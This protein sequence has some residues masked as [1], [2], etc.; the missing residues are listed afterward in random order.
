MKV[1]IIIP[2][3]NESETLLDIIGRVFAQP[4]N[5]EK[6]IVI[7]D[8]KSTDSSL[9]ILHR[10]KQEYNFALCEHPKNLGK[11]AALNTGLTQATGDIILFQDADLEY[12]PADWPKLIALFDDQR[13]QVVYGCRTSAGY[14]KY[15]L[16]S[17][18]LTSFINLLYGADLKD[19]Y[20][21]YKVIRK[22]LLDNLEIKS[23]GFEFEAE[24]TAKILRRGIQIIQV[25]ISYNPRTFAEG[26]K[27]RFLRDGILGLW[28]FI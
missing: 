7:V 23:V 16:G 27:I 26:K 25:P 9:E 10:L 18:V 4:I 2:V 1:S 12:N 22:S 8:D 17:K 21:C 14:K 13:T 5:C 19:P 24:L 20:T 28:T 11:G 6:E 3:Y 15:Y